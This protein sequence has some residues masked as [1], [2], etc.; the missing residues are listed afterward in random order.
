[1]EQQTSLAKH[2]QDGLWNNNPALVQLLGLCPLLAV[3]TSLTN[4]LG[5]GI[6]TLFVLITSSL[7]V[8][9]IRDHVPASVRLP[10]FVLI[11]AS[12]TTCAE[13]MIQ[14]W[15]LK[16]YN[17]LGI[18]I[19]LIVTNCLILGRAEAFAARSTPAKSSLD[20]LSMGS[21]FAL[22][23]ILLGALRELVGTGAIGAGLNELLPLGEQRIEGWR[24]LE[25]YHGFIIAILPPGAFI[26]VGLLVALH[27]RIT[28]MVQA[29]RAE[30]VIAG[31]KRVRV[32]QGL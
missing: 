22:V 29:R 27:K 6:A 20:A 5:L 18:F 21:G 25:N 14:A 1:M 15:A 16:L 7:L 11:I 12:V 19:P 28:Q 8:S 30:Q 13:L 24:V 26:S 23:L 2:L 4:A 3:S 10:I 9:C 31:K 32:T 17:A